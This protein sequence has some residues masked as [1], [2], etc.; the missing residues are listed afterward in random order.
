LVQVTPCIAKAR[1]PPPATLAQMPIDVQRFFNRSFPQTLQVALILLYVRAFFSF[2]ELAFNSDNVRLARGL[3]PGWGVLV[4]LAMV[5]LHVGAGYLMAN[6][7]KV[8]YWMAIAAALSPL[9]LNL[10]LYSGL[11]GLSFY[12]KISGRSTISL[13]FDVAF[14]AVVLHPMSRNYQRIWFK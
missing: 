13:I 1:T 10:W 9:L 8:G 14:I 12:D 4:L 5:A 3:R 2:F 11:R 6:E 7:R